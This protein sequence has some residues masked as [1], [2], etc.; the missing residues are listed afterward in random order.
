MTLATRM[1]I[2][3]VLQEHFLI[4]NAR[5]LLKNLSLMVLVL[6]NS[7]AGYTGAEETIYESASESRE[8]RS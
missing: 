1:C 2:M 6:M 8:E 7:K 5:R 3:P 4:G